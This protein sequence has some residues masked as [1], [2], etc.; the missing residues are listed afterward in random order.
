MQ[1][2]D[3]A[4]ASGNIADLSKASLKADLLVTEI[5][6]NDARIVANLFGRAIGDR[7]AVIEHWQRKSRRILSTRA[8]IP[9]TPATATPIATARTSSARRK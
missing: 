7:F 3:V 2:G 5:G 8:T 1:D 9:K 6:G 4:V